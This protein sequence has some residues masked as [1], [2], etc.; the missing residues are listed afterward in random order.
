MRAAQIHLG[1]VWPKRDARIWRV[2][3]PRVGAYAAADRHAL[4]RIAELFK[5][6][7]FSSK[8]LAELEAVA[9][10]GRNSLEH[11]AVELIEF[12][13]L[14]SNGVGTAQNQ[15]LNFSGIRDAKWCTYRAERLRAAWAA[16]CG[17]RR[18]VANATRAARRIGRACVAWRVRVRHNP[19][20][21]WRSA[22]S[23]LC[24]EADATGTRGKWYGHG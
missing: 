9:L 6:R 10:L 3:A 13:A 21:A 23:A 20:R 19:T 14:T 18:D 7:L 17:R 16:R 24:Q 5:V 15:L 2:C 22:H 12:D 11:I 4:P 8:V 1:T